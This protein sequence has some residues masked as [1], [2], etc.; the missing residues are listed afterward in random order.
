MP[1][2][3]KRYYRITCFQVHA[4]YLHGR[5]YVFQ[6]DNDPR[7]PA[8]KTAE[9]LTNGRLW[10]GRHSHHV[11]DPHPIESMW[12]E[13]KNAGARKN[14]RNLKELRY[15]YLEEWQKIPQEHCQNLVEG[16]KRRLQAVIDA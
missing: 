16:Y 14:P 4:G 2:N 9:L 10:T 3:I 8:K 13:L 5:K 11:P 12:T 6:H 1:Q 7:H 15:I